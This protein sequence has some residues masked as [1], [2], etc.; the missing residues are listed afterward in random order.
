MHPQKVRLPLRKKD[1]LF[2]WNETN[3]GLAD[4]DPEALSDY[5]EESDSEAEED[6]NESAGREHYEEVGKSKLRKQEAPTLGPQYKGSRVSRDAAFDEDSDDPFS[7]E[8]GNE[9]ES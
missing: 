4:F 8:F 9:E 5:G 6:S 1:F 7:R 2:W 3:I